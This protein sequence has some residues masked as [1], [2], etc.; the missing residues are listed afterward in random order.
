MLYGHNVEYR[1][2]SHHQNWERRK[3]HQN[4]EGEKIATRGI[5]GWVGIKKSQVCDCN[6]TITPFLCA[7][8]INKD[9]ALIAQ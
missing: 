4:G 5:Y 1:K 9:W 2:P 6:Y 3:F 7:T 8:H